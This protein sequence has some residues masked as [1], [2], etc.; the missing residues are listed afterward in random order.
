MATRQSLRSQSGDPS[1]TRSCGLP[2]YQDPQEKRLCRSTAW[3]SGAVLA[4]CLIVA[5][6]ST[7]KPLPNGTSSRG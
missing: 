6:S 2:K 5:G 3:S 4:E 1:Y 7:S